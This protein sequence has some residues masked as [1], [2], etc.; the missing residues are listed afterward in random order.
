LNMV[1]SKNLRKY[2]QE[3]VMFDLY[4]DAEEQG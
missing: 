4:L 1:S 3:R 2:R